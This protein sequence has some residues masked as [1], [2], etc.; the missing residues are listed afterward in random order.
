MWRGV[1]PGMVSTRPPPPVPL[2][3]VSRK[4][5]YR[6]TG[7][8][9]R[10]PERAGLAEPPLGLVCGAC[11]GMGRFANDKKKVKN[12]YI[13]TFGVGNRPKK[14]HGY[15]RT[16][17][18]YYSDS[19]IAAYFNQ[20]KNMD[21]EASW[22]GVYGMCHVSMIEFCFSTRPLGHWVIPCATKWR[23]YPL[24]GADHGRSIERP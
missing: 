24:R 19:I 22:I 18:L 3:L 8:H 5:R 6:S 14:I 15:I 13:W 7:T 23:R 16:S 1:D 2:L 12:M 11:S 20:Q 17:T 9:P 21:R 4:R 10:R